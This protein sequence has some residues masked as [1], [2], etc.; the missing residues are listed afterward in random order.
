M[1]EPSVTARRR[2]PRVLESD[3]AGF[4]RRLPLGVKPAI[5]LVD[6]VRAYF[7]PGAQLYMGIDE[8][9][10]VAGEVLSA[11]REA[12]IPVIH[13]RVSFTEG[14]SDGGFFFQKVGALAHFVG[15]TS[16]GELVPEL[17]PR[18]TEPVLVKQYASAFFGTSLS[19]TL[20]SQGIDT[21]IIMGVS[22]SGCIRAT[23]VDAIQ[24]GFLPVVVRDGVGDRADGPHEASLYDIQAKY[25]EVRSSTEVLAYLRGDGKNRS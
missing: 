10:G 6:F 15:D 3:E 21:L 14:G 13:T 19:S 11:A 24:H 12:G 5:V 7:E 9:L 1:T 4:E 18:P 16:L 20:T 25:G 17:A 23:A 2:D 22:T 8:C